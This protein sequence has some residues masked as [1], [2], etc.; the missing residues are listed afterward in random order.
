MPDEKNKGP[1]ILRMRK[2]P[3]L[4][5][6]AAFIFISFI[7]NISG[8][9]PILS[10]LSDFIF[11]IFLFLALMATANEIIAGIAYEK[12][13]N[14]S[15]Q[16]SISNDPEEES[17]PGPG[18]IAKVK[19]LLAKA[20]H[21]EDADEDDLNSDPVEKPEADANKYTQNTAAEVYDGL[22]EI[23]KDSRH[24]QRSD[25]FSNK[26]LQNFIGILFL[27][28]FVS[29]AYW[30]ISIIFAALPLNFNE[31]YDYG[32]ITSLLLL[33]FPCITVIYLKMRNNEITYPG[34]KASYDM[35]M[36]SACLLS[37]FSAVIT[38]NAVLNM[39]LLFI[40][41]WVY[42]AVSL[43]LFLSLAV[44]ILFSILKNDI[45]GHFSYAIIPK[46]LKTDSIDSSFIDSEEVRLNF[47][48]KSLYTIKYTLKILPWL[49][50]SLGFILML[51][52]TIFVVRPY[53]QAAV[54]RLGRLERSSIAGEGLHFK[55]PWPVDIVEIFDVHR[56]GYLQIGYEAFD[57]M[58][59]LWARGPYDEEYLLLTGNGNEVVAVSI[60]IIYKIS[61]LYSYITTNAN[62][63]AL[64]TAAAHS[65]LMNRT[66][67]TTLDTFLSIDRNLLS[68]SISYELSQFSEAE[69]LGLSVVQVII[70]NINPPAEIAD[71]YQRVVTASVEKNTIITNARSDAEQM[72]I[73]AQLLSNMA[74]YN[75]ITEQHDRVSNAQKS[76][77]VYFAAM[78]AYEINPESFRLITMLSAYETVIRG[79]RVHIFSPGMEDSI[80]NLIIN[81]INIIYEFR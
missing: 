69:R 13:D 56:I 8:I 7:I 80:S 12:E 19:A 5:G 65:A 45:V 62:P 21:K 79:N 39:N 59:F 76:M 1:S 78:E 2:F 9:S 44:N 25:S 23:K 81:P 54:Y 70:E 60:K 28:S 38:A 24:E 3:L 15:E 10:V 63:E 64:L 46:T 37:I 58:N 31:Y 48:V 22:V 29:I 40:L 34:D 68:A 55:L 43:Y 49:V 47:S 11:T 53:Q 32:I 51:S 4:L 50:L 6:F 57:N 16:Y 75:A 74:I 30:R 20:S 72:L 77:A 26:K 17:A 67:N 27:I 33:V 71:V 18:F 52:T 41:P 36:L 66:V 42:Y 35:L 61:D 14:T 73:N